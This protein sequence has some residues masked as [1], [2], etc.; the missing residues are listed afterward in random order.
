MEVMEVDREEDLA[1]RPNSIPPVCLALRYMLPSLPRELARDFLGMPSHDGA[2]VMHPRPID[3]VAMALLH[4]R[5]HGWTVIR[6]L[7]GADFLRDLSAHA[8]HLAD[9]AH[10]AA[11]HNHHV[12]RGT[13]RACLN[14]FCNPTDDPVYKRLRMSLW[15]DNL[16]LRMMLKQISKETYGDVDEVALDHICGGDSVRPGATAQPW[17]SDWPGASDA[18]I[19]V[20]IITHD[21]PCD[22]APMATISRSAGN[23]SDA[24]AFDHNFVPETLL[25]HALHVNP[26]AGTLLIRDVSC[27]HRGSANNASVARVLPCIRFITSKGLRHHKYKPMRIMSE[28]DWSSLPEDCQALTARLFREDGVDL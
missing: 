19:A 1:M 16:Q 3:D 24:H 15:Q 12:A 2:P 10:A 23:P 20:S 13:G 11:R 17:H 7:L 18:C 21:F 25:P 6:S 9:E 27:W 26:P 28:S 5:M 14:S 8:D 4:Y 22:A